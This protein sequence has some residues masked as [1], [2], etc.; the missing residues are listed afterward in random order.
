MSETVNG[1]TTESYDYWLEY[2]IHK[3]NGT[4]R[5]D[6]ESDCIKKEYVRV[7]NRNGVIGIDA[8]IPYNTEEKEP[9]R[10]GGDRIVLAFAASIA[11][12]GTAC[13]AGAL[14]IKK[15]H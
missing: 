1:Y 12:V 8:L 15:K 11:I 6:M 9:S 14:I 2:M 5:N 13:V 3:N 10:T 4:F 7:T